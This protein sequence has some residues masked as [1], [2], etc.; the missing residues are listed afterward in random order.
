MHIMVFRLWFR[1]LAVVLFSL[2]F[3]IAGQAASIVNGSFEGGPEIGPS[4]SFVTLFGG[5]TAIPGWTVT[6]ATIDYIGPSW[7]V[8]DG[9][10]AVDL[11]GNSSTGG[12]QQTFA[13]TAGTPY[14]VSFDLAGN[15]DGP[16]EVK[17]VRVSAGDFTQDFSFDI[18][19]QTRS[20]L[21]WQPTSFNFI[22]PDSTTTLSFSSLST[23]GNSFGATIDN[24]DVKVVPIPAALWLFASGL[25]SLFI[26]ARKRKIA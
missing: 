19:G 14:M 24:V 1:R 13:T 12:I 18:Q 7:L 23:V 25:S 21:D 6:G 3:P 5:S 2:T 26:Y 8:S 20:T 17:Q 15:P 4:S 16:P 10:R 11:D 9:I 22:A